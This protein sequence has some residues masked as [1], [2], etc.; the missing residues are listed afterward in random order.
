MDKKKAGLVGVQLDVS[1]AIKD[2]LPRKR[3]PKCIVKLIRDSYE[4]AA[5]KIKQGT[6]EVSLQ[7][8]QGV[9]QGDPLSPFKFDGMLELLILQLENQHRYKINDHCK[10]SSLA[11]AYA[12]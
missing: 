7:I 11:F 1:E 3:I 4:D 9:K 2:A 6:V 12:I 8:R 5:T 10:V